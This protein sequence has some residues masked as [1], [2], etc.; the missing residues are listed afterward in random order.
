MKLRLGTVQFG[1]DYGI[2]GQKKPGLEASIACLEYAAAN[3]V[4]SFDTAEAYGDA[5]WI[6]GEFL[7]RG[8]AS[9]E[10]L[11]ISTKLLPNSL[12]GV[13]SEELEAVIALRLGESL[14]RL[15]TSY[16]D[17]YLLHSSR[18]AFRADILKAL[19]SVKEKGL[20]RKV[21]VS[22]YDPE[23]AFACIDS[24]LVDFMQAP[25]SIFDRR[26]KEAGVLDAASAAGVEFDTRSAFIQGLVTMSPSDVPPFLEEAVPI[27]KKLDSI[28]HETGIS[29]VDLAMGYVAREDA[30]SALVFGV[31]SLGQLEE[32]ICAFG[33]PL[34]TDV[35]ELMNREFSGISAEVVMPSLW[36][37]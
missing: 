27:L 18:Y 7:S 25:Y 10:N 17:A 14:S 23:E 13:P 22:V 35:I 21:G 4:M 9:R 29:R 37:R 3:G 33:R 15:R 5:E 20:A 36:K 11:S 26:M 34:P 32:D 6:V 16:V 24:G 1:M 31:D 8:S 19:Q 2:A 30:V 12:D 28:A